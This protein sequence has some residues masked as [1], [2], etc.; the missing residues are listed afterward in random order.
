MQNLWSMFLKYCWCKQG[1]CTLGCRYISKQ[2]YWTDCYL[3]RYITWSTVFAEFVLGELRLCPDVGCVL[4]CCRIAF[5]TSF[6]VI[7]IY[8]FPRA[9]YVFS[10][11]KLIALK[12][13]LNKIFK[14]LSKLIGSAVNDFKDDK[15]SHNCQF[16]DVQWYTYFITYSPHS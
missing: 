5:T 15:T 4:R 2:I 14:P 3:L 12:K 11:S 9:L 10:W 16:F 8:D 7:F 13:K 1:W 6:H